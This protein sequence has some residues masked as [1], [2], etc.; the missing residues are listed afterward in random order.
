MSEQCKL[1]K[2]QKNF[3]GSNSTFDFQGLLIPYDPEKVEE[4]VNVGL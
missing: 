3:S 2:M 1:L 4:L